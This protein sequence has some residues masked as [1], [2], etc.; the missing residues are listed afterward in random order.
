MAETEIGKDEMSVLRAVQIRLKRRAVE[1]SSVSS[2]VNKVCVLV[3]FVAVSMGCASKPQTA[4]ELVFLT[5]GGCVNTTT[6]RANLDAALKAMNRPADYQ[7]VDQDTLAKTDPRTGY[8]TPTV[9]VANRDLF[10][11][12]EP[13]PPFPEPT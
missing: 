2:D 1:E 12:P 4:N 10:G 8:A 11:L 13:T 3:L 9:L 7:L 6:M 5:R